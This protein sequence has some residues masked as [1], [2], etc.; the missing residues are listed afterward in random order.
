MKKKL[1]RNSLTD[2]SRVP[3]N[4][5]K[6]QVFVSKR[7][8][9]TAS[10]NNWLVTLAGSAVLN[11]DYSGIVAILPLA[12]AKRLL[13]FNKLVE[14]KARS[15]GRSSAR[16]STRKQALAMIPKLAVLYGEQLPRHRPP[17]IN[18]FCKWI[19]ITLQDRASESSTYAES[20]R[21][22]ELIDANRNVRWWQDQLRKM[23]S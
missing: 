22:Y 10:S 11:K 8:G 2:H 15:V 13:K 3:I 17:R 4:N 19:V 9:E 7:T 21:F 16:E 18:E 12:R 23:Q 14:K 20:R 1:D 5:K 6:H